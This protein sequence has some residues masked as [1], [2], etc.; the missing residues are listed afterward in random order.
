MLAIANALRDR[1]AEVLL[2]GG[3]AGTEFVSLHG[4]D[5][6]EPTTVDYIDTYQ[7]GSLGQ[8]LARSVPASARRVAEY[9]DWLG[10]TDPDA[11]VTDDMFAAMAASRTDVP[12]YVLKHD[13]PGLYR[14][15]VE[16]S[17]ARFHTA[18]QSAVTREFF[19]PAV[20]PPAAIDPDFATRIPPVSLDEPDRELDECDRDGGGEV[21]EAADVVLVPSHYSE[22]DRLAAR[23]EREGHDVLHVGADDWEPVPS[24]LPYIRG[25]DAVVCSGYSTVMDAAVAGTP[26]VVWP[27]TDEQEAVAEQL[28]R[29]DVDGFAVADDALDV[30][31]AVES[32]PSATPSDNGADVVAERVVEDLAGIAESRIDGS[33]PAVASSPVPVPDGG[34][35]PTRRRTAL[36]D[37]GKGLSL[38]VRTLLGVGLSVR[39][40]RTRLVGRA[41]RAAASTLS[42]VLLAVLVV[43]GLTARGRTRR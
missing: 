43:K 19:Y 41:E 30:L 23:L 42:G 27:E 5:E 31:D 3:G 28:A 35:S 17:G 32:P 18:F 24:L 12:L 11:L 2:A 33:S 10:E 13:V 40:A 34:R 14:D 20:W 22:F 4:Y 21:R 15:P 7:G 36:F 39:D 37:G 8:V 38:A 16:R 29:P 9:V 6:F 26:C 1:G 25:A